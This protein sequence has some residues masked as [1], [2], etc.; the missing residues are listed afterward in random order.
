TAQVEEASKRAL[1]PFDRGAASGGKAE[2]PFQVQYDLQEKM[3]NLV[4]I[5]RN[6]KEMKEA[7]GHRGQLWDRARQ[8][9]V[10]GSREYRPGWHTALDL[11]N[12]LTVSE[13]ITRSALERRESRGGHFRDDFPDKDPAFATFNIVVRK[14]PGGGMEISRVPIPPLPA[15][16]KAVIE[17]MK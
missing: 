3:Q 9:G 12:L 15:E 11:T 6:E 17:E 8:V 7:L 14:A 4:G 1:S 10:P 16:L 5:V 13:A 2:A